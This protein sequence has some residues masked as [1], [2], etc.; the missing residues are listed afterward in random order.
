MVYIIFYMVRP[1]NWLIKN[2]D[3][4]CKASSLIHPK[5]IFVPVQSLSL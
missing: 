4:V 1:I 5:G 3:T 2:V